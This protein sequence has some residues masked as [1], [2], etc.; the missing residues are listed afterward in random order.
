MTNVP[1]A[2]KAKGDEARALLA[3]MNGTKE[4]PADEFVDVTATQGATETVA[5]NP[6]ENSDAANK[7]NEQQLAPDASGSPAA[8][9]QGGL[10]D[11]NQPVDPSD[12]KE[13]Y[14]RLRATRDE[15]LTQAENELAAT[16]QSL[17]HA[18]ARVAELEAGAKANEPNP[19]AFELTD[20]Q[21][22]E[23]TEN[24]IA[25]FENLAAKMSGRIEQVEQTVAQKATNV[26]DLYYEDLDALVPTWESINKNQDFLNWLLEVDP[27]TGVKRQITLESLDSLNRAEDVAAIFRSFLN[28]GTASDAAAAAAATSTTNGSQPAGQAA[29]YG[30]SRADL[31][32][33]GG[34]QDEPVIVSAHAFKQFYTDLGKAKRNGNYR[35]QKAQWDAKKKEFDDASREGRIR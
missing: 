32:T 7:S 4:T 22:E 9:E 11:R 33:G 28:A 35:K 14:T 18:E 23:M 27:A 31:H 10:A 30:S 15:K 12:W 17:A 8:A 2:T 16:K 5:Y 19:H 13:R 26:R 20:E 24:E 29:N 34:A 21:R 25:V 1:D 6:G 3:K